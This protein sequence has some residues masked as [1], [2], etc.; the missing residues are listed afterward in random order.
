[1]SNKNDDKTLQKL[2]MSETVSAL[3]VSNGNITEAA[4]SLGKN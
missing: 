2:K 1:M 3:L 4:K